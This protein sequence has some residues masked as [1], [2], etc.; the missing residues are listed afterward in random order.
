MQYKI[1]YDSEKGHDFQMKKNV[2]KHLP[3]FF[4]KLLNENL[5]YK[6][7]KYLLVYYFVIQTKSTYCPQRDYFFCHKKGDSILVETFA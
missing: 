7:Q 3:T 1:V 2:L 6:Y 4:Q 5:I